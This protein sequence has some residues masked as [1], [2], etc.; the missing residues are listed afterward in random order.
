[1]ATLVAPVAL[2]SSTMPSADLHNQVLDMAKMN[3]VS[4]SGCVSVS[5][6]VCQTVSGWGI[7]CVSE[8]VCEWVGVSGLV[9]YWVCQ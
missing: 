6:R 4:V 2:C 8:C 5:V 1:M 7:G 9:G 3:G